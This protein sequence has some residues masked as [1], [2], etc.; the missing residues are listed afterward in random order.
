ML[1]LSLWK[2]KAKMAKNLWVYR[3]HFDTSLI[4]KS[5]G[6][7]KGERRPARWITVHVKTSAR[8]FQTESVS[9][10]LLFEQWAFNVPRIRSSLTDQ[11]S[12]RPNTLNLNY[13]VRTFTY[14]Y[15]PLTVGASWQKS[16]YP[17]PQNMPFIFWR[18][19]IFPTISDSD[20][21]FVFFFP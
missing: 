16:D 13:I 3:K 7:A 18:Q 11:I 4:T 14:I 12:G 9:F 8:V 19:K 15:I 1:S 6:G 21:L 5:D 17:F 20:F 10:S 2:I